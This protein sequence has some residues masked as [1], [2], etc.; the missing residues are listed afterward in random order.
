[1]ALLRLRHVC[2]IWKDSNLHTDCK[3]YNVGVLLRK[4]GNSSLHRN[5]SLQTKLWFTEIC[6]HSLEKIFIRKII[7]HTNNLLPVF[8]VEALLDIGDSKVWAIIIL[9]RFKKSL[10]NEDE[11]IKK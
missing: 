2:C 4:Y 5:A 9:S 6:T 7:Y 1:M 3:L 11:D 10:R 8:C